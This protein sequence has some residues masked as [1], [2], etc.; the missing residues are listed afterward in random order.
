MPQAP[1]ILSVDDAAANRYV[2]AHV[3]RQA[4][5]TVEEAVSGQTALTQL[6]EMNPKPDLVLLDVHLPD[7][8]GFEVCRQIKA[9]PHTAPIPVLQISA[10]Y[11]ATEERVRGL[12]GGADGYLISPVDPDELV[13]NVGALIRIRELVQ[14]EQR[15][16]SVLDTVRIGTWD[17]NLRT[18]EISWSPNHA[19]LF[20]FEPVGFN[21]SYESFR[22]QIH[23]DDLP[24]LEAQM[25]AAR[26][27]H[28]V[29]QCEYRVQWPDGS[30]HWLEGKGYYSYGGGGAPTW[31]TGIV[32]D[33]SERREAELALQASDERFRTALATVAHELR[34]P[35]AAI[36]NALYVL[37]H[38]QGNEDGRSRALAMAERQVVQQSRLIDDLMDVA[39]L[40]RGKLTIEPERVDLGRLITET[41][42]DFAA[43]AAAA[44]VSLCCEL[45]PG[46]LSVDGEPARLMQ[47]VGNLL[48][49]ALKFT[50][51][52]GSVSV[53]LRAGPDRIAVL[54]IH[55]T[56][57]G[58]EADF[59]PRAFESFAQRDTGS[60]RGHGGL[61]LGLAL[62]Q[63][64]VHLHGGEISIQSPGP[65]QGCTVRVTLPLS[66]S[67][68]HSS[69]TP[70]PAMGAGPGRRVL[71]VEDNVDSADSLRE[72]L[73]LKGHVVQVAYTGTDGL[74][75]ARQSL[76]EV[77]ISDLGLPG[78][79][80]FAVARALRSDAQL[81][82]AHLIALSGYGQEQDVERCRAAGF[83]HHF[84]KPVDVARLLDYLASLP[85]S[86]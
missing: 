80:G 69:P 60:S 4:G 55:D 58:M 65:G 25:E 32:T 50:P 42:A 59:L 76:P 29:F 85:P 64:L 15:L 51:S 62:T 75:Q 40:G 57:V 8:D 48:S 37:H 73:E 28:S 78:M 2:V 3:L 61:G 67:A 16:R 19:T 56:G 39:R 17:W 68:D 5:Y 1:V 36:Q 24:L 14:K 23:P 13:A 34:N 35:L 71:V 63:G 43:Q 82:S 41:V 86:D 12:M 53:S 21:G 7:V 74:E 70:V 11:T 30:V 18:N 81:R 6:R 79:D 44:D 26:I 83:D 33:V 84:I 27:G 47:I 77:V 52:G 9:D 38:A 66:A 45:S 20:G 46:D 54:T 49:N 10:H 31:L 72:L 22:R